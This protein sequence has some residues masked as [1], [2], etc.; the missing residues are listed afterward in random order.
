ME[1]VI[2]YI[3]TLLKQPSNVFRNLSA[4]VKHLAYNNAIVAMWPEFEI[5]KENPRGCRDFGDGYWLLGPKD[6]DLYQLPDME[7]TA[8]DNFCSGEPDSEDLERQSLYRW[9]R[10]RLPTDQIARSRLK[11]VKRCQDMSR[12]DCHVK[13][14]NFR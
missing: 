9:A 10:L 5:Q 14:G 13:V 2:G 12:T 8:L 1:C 11:E 3:G 4:Q 7:K 6:V